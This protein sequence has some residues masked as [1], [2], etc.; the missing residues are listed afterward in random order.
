MDEKANKLQELEQLR[1]R[2]EQLERELERKPED[3]QPTGY[4]TA[5]YATTGFM[6]GTFG[7]MAS[8]VFNIV[9]SLIFGK[10][11]L[12]LIRVYLTFPLGERALH[13]D[14]GLT[15]A[16]GVCLYILTGMLLGVFVHLFLTRFAAHASLAGRL[17]WATV[18]GLGIWIVNFYGLLSWIQPMLIGGNWIVQLIPPWVAALTHLVFTWTM[19]IAYPLGLYVPY[20]PPAEHQ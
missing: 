19:A 12:E 3:W 18:L 1:S 2:L 14:D 10:H 6:L 15:L 4:Y 17:L 11:P 20:R 7:A 13:M 16:I 8:L 9:G 5:Y